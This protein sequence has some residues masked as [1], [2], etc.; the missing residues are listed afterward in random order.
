MRFKQG[1]VVAKHGIPHCAKNIGAYLNAEINTENIHKYLQQQ[2]QANS[3]I[4]RAFRKIR[5][6]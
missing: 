4:P 1:C 3:Q 6:I 2:N 5:R